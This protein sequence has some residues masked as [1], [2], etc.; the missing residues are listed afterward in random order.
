LIAVL[1]I[2]GPVGVGKSSVAAQVASRLGF[3][4][5]DTGAMYRAVAWKL[6]QL[7]PA[8]WNHV[9]VLAE[10]ARALP[11][12]L[13]EDGR[14]F[15]EDTDVTLA[16]R[17]EAV[18]RFVGRV[19]DA[20]VVRE[21]LVDQQ[22]RVGSERPSV[23]EG[24]DIGTVVFPDAALKIY[25]D[26]SPNVRVQRRVEQLL[27]MG[28][29]AHPDEVHTALLERDARDRARP[30]GALRVAEDAVIL[31]TTCLCESRVVETICALASEVPAFRNHLT[32]VAP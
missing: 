19:A 2:D 5:L 14:I 10:L 32:G 17:D 9:A 31:D 27:A 12:R 7:P 8:E 15:V 18:S 25:L 26:A 22:R 24:R 6:M 30:W 28:K 21:A 11:I 3:R 13:E 29:A 20:R 23:L 1:A 16:I 4:H